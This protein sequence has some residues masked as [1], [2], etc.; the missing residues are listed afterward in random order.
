MSHVFST[1]LLAA[2][3]DERLV[4][5][6]REGHERAFE[7]LVERH[8]SSLLRYCRRMRLPDWRAEEVLQHAFLQAWLA[9][10]S[11]T[12][13]ANPRSWLYRIVHNGAVNAMRGP[14]DD[15][16]PLTDATHVP[17]SAAAVSDLDGR[18]ALREALTDVAGLPQMQRDAIFLTAVDG[19]SHAEV[20]GALGITHDAVR[21]LIYRARATLRGAAAAITPQPLIGWASAGR[22]APTAERVAQLSASGGAAGMT[23]VL[24]K[25]AAVAVTAGAIVA[26]AAVVPAHHEGARRA[27]SQASPV[28][29]AS[30]AGDSR[31][32]AAPTVGVS[33]ASPSLSGAQMA[34]GGLR[35]QVDL[36]AGH[37]AR[38]APSGASPASGPGVSGPAV[39]LPSDAAAGPRDAQGLLQGVAPGS[40]GDGSGMKVL[41]PVGQGG[42]G[43]SAPPPGARH[44]DPSG[45][46]G[47]NPAGP[48][49]G[50]PEQSPGLPGST[51]GADG[52]AGAGPGEGGAAPGPGGAEGEPHEARAGGD[53]VSGD[54]AGAPHAEPGS[55]VGD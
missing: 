45:G 6:V 3:S 30:S 16:S 19:Q 11:G 22:A 36:S 17:A 2:Q 50:G 52:P 31:S 41:M 42:S 47:E 32:S 8:R 54:G 53:H 29:A 25:G 24:L 5:L 12:E 27:Q 9:L 46:Q 43:A 18:M 37:R 51:S 49:G 1:R 21:G 39:A 48:A 14:A 7:T 20:A 55:A 26:G 15:H 23:G 10:R 13:V 34:Q 33:L 44:T 35:A 40:S 38:R 4:A 28:A